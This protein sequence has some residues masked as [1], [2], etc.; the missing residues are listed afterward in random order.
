MCAAFPGGQADTRQGVRV[1]CAPIGPHEC[2][3]VQSGV[4]G[5]RASSAARTVLAQRRFV[6]AVSSGFACALVPASVGD[7]LLGTEVTMVG[8]TGEAL[9]DLLAVAGSDRDAVQIGRAH[10]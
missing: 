7:V 8:K 10:V 6:L 5:A 4:G 2:W 3:V 9:S 1:Y